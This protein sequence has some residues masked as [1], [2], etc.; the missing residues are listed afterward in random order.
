MAE[1][2]D[3]NVEGV[4]EFLC[5]CIETSAD[6]SDAEVLFQI[7]RSKPEYLQKMARVLLIQVNSL[8]RGLLSAQATAFSSGNTS[9]LKREANID[10]IHSLLF[11]SVLKSS[12]I[13]Q[14]LAD[15]MAGK[16]LCGVVENARKLLHGSLPDLIDAL[17]KP[18]GSKVLTPQIDR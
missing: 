17:N 18:F 7:F 4:A 6:T 14:S 8:I 1:A 2:P 3:V 12:T 13:L 5:R 10:V 16:Y 15:P 11:K 9:G